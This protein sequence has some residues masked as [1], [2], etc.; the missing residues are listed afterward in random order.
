MAISTSYSVQQFAKVSGDQQVTGLKT[1]GDLPTANA[2][3]PRSGLLG[4]AAKVVSDVR[5][6]FSAS[7]RGEQVA[8]AQQAAE[9][10]QAFVAAIRN[11]YGTAVASQLQSG[12]PFAQLLANAPALTGSTIQKGLQLAAATQQRLADQAIE[13]RLSLS[14][15]D[16][17]AD[18]LAACKDLGVD[19]LSLDGAQ[20][21][22]ID[23]WM[24]ASGTLPHFEVAASHVGSHELAAQAL[25]AAIAAAQLDH[26][27]AAKELALLLPNKTYVQSADSLAAA[28]QH[29]F[30]RELMVLS[31]Q[32]VVNALGREAVSSLSGLMSGLLQLNT[33]YDS[34]LLSRQVLAGVYGKDQEAGADDFNELMSSAFEQAI[35]RRPLDTGLA[36]LHKM[37]EHNIQAPQGAVQKLYVAGAD[38]AAGRIRSAAVDMELSMRM[39]ARLPTMLWNLASVVAADAQWGRE[40][41]DALLD[42]HRDAKLT[43]ADIDQVVTQVNMQRVV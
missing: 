27:G 14:A 21:R 1:K 15:R 37:V 25:K 6:F 20:R 26:A 16:S 32:P 4:F 13:A 8:R 29:A 28:R 12:G 36:V 34:H 17:G 11:E 23:E 33:A 2:Q 42:V 5:A 40:R 39:G 24:K 30:T 22:Q 35:E 10:K 7:Y 18:F 3:A 9:A 43:Q 31:A 19:P 41:L 38:L